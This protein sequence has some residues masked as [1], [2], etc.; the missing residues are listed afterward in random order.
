ME[1]CSLRWVWLALGLLS[2]KS[3]KVT[4]R[5]LWEDSGHAAANLQDA[6]IYMITVRA[7]TQPCTLNV[8]YLSCLRLGKKH[9]QQPVCSTTHQNSHWGCGYSVLG[10]T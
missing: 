10:S 8:C 5:Y 6:T 9:P 1:C 7:P 2:W 4:A 3:W